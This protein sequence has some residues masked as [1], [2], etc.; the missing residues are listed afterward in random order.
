MASKNFIKKATANSHGQF[1]AKAQA[2][3]MSTAAYASKKKHAKGLTGEQAR[4]ATTL[5][6]LS[7]HKKTAKK[8]KS[9]LKITPPGYDSESTT[10]DKSEGKEE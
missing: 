10:E 3:G 6:G 1:R 8:S 2:A 5:M 9:P 7:K 4:L